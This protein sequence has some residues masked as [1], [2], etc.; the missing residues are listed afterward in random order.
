MVACP[1]CKMSPQEIQCSSHAMGTVI[2]FPRSTER[3][4]RVWEES[5]RNTYRGSHFD[6]DVVEDSLVAI[7]RH[8]ST[9]F[10]AVSLQAAPIAIP[11]PLTDAQVQAIDHAA[12]ASGAVVIERLKRERT[13]SLGLL[14][15]AEMMLAYHRHHGVPSGQS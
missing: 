8:W 13:V 5:I 15:Q 3:D 10:E 9:L 6:A 14:I 11:G 1:K 12:R 4:W 2:E 7:K